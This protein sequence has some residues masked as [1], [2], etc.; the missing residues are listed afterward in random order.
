[1]IVDV[2]PFVASALFV[3]HV[4]GAPGAGWG[5]GRELAIRAGAVLFDVVWC[6]LV[7]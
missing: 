2:L 1:M 7:L 5:E 3:S 4:Q 6:C